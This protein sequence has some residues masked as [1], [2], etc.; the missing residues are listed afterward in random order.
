V[1]NNPACS[2][3]I[4]QCVNTLFDRYVH[5]PSMQV[6]EVDDFGLLAAQARLA[7]GNNADRS[8]AHRFEAMGWGRRSRRFIQCCTV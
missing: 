4:I 1:A 7:G 3:Q 8:L 2:D 6:I 5:I